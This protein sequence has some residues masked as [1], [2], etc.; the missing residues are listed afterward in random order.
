MDYQDTCW[1]DQLIWIFLQVSDHMH[2]G[3][4]IYAQRFSNNDRPRFSDEE[5]MTIYLFGITQGHRTLKAIYRYIRNHLHAWFPGLPSY[6]CC[7]KRLNRLHGVFALLNALLVE[8]IHAAY[9]QS[10]QRALA[11][12]QPTH[13][14]AYIRDDEPVCLVDAYPIVMARGARWDQARVALDEAGKGYCA[15]KRL[16]Y[17]GL[18]LHA[19]LARRTDRLP[20]VCLLFATS[21]QCHDLSALQSV[22]DQ[23]HDGH[24]FGDKIYGDAPLQAHLAKEQNLQLHTPVRRKK[25]Q[26][27]LLLTEQAYSMWVSQIRQPIESF[28]NWLEAKTGIQYA[29]RV[30]SSDGL[31]VHVFGRLVAALIM[32]MLNC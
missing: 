5:L 20:V 23:I 16:Y 26:T 2:E 31:K 18:K 24:L 14:A 32:F 28:F 8:S 4:S 22:I 17:H 3:L 27:H 9:Q 21:A 7:N 11:Q 12:G 6:V 30:R 10:F 25:G 15:T 29:S 13:G 19:I 1:E